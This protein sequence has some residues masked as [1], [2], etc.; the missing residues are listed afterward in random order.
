MPNKLLAG[1]HKHH[2]IPKHV[3]GTDDPKN[4]MALHP[5]DH[6]IAHLVNYKM[7]GRWQDRNAAMV[8]GWDPEYKEIKRQ[9]RLD[10]QGKN[11]V[12]CRDEVRQKIKEAK[13][14]KVCVN[15]VIFMGV[16]EAARQLKVQPMQIC[17]RI[18]GAKARVS[19][20]IKDAYY[21]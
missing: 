8:L 19:S 12:A 11:N 4:I 21:M 20:K 6:M 14:K 1:F 2:I 17:R 15:G 3:G 18:K 7:F 10:M 5:I 13:S 9:P 16:Q